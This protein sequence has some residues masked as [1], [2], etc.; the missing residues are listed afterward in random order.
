MYHFNPFHAFCNM[1]HFLGDGLFFEQRG[2]NA[3]EDFAVPC[4]G[5]DL[6]ELIHQSGIH[7]GAQCQIIKPTLAVMSRHETRPLKCLKDNGNSIIGAHVVDMDNKVIEHR[8]SGV[9]TVE[10]N[11]PLAALPVIFDQNPAS[12][13]CGD[14]F[15]LGFFPDPIFKVCDNPNL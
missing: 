9:C 15:A 4:S 12:F 5:S 13:L 2:S 3:H 11:A 1:L 8:V 10:M 14:S 7:L 6:G